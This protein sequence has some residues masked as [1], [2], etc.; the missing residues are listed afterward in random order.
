MSFA[1]PHM[2]RL[3]QMAMEEELLKHLPMKQREGSRI[4]CRHAT[5]HRLARARPLI[6][7]VYTPSVTW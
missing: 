5:P 1:L 2:P 4:I 3:M 7:L 6:A